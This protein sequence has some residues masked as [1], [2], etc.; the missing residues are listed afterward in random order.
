MGNEVRQIRVIIADDHLAVRKAIRKLLNQKQDILIVGESGNGKDTLRIV[1][2]LAPDVLLL[3]IDMPELDGVEVARRLRKQRSPV[4]IL[5]V[6]GYSDQSYI[7]LVMNEGVSGYLVK[8]EAPAK[9]AEA[10]RQ[11]ARGNYQASTFNSTFSRVPA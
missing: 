3:D 1:N 10:I 6:S 8:D 11:A 9:L 4:Q 2:E 5:V 7:R